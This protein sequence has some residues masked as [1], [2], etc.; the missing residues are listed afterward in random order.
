MRFGKGL[1]TGQARENEL[2][3]MRWGVMRWDAMGYDGMRCDGIRL[4]GAR[5]DSTPCTFVKDVKM[6]EPGWASG[7]GVD[8]VPNY[9]HDEHNQERCSRFHVTE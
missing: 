3:E 9:E 7:E 1:S 5:S 8:D 6:S 4:D 2:D